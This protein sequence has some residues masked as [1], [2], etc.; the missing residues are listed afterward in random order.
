M[1]S[2]PIVIGALSVLFDIVV[3]GPFH[4]HFRQPGVLP[5]A[6]EALCLYGA[7]LLAWQRLPRFALGITIVVGWLY[8]RRHHVD[9][10]A[11]AGWIYLEGIVAFGALFLR[12][13]HDAGGRRF[14]PPGMSSMLVGVAIWLV[15]MIGVSALGMGRPGHLLAL[16]ALVLLPALALRWRET[17]ALQFGGALR[18]SSAGERAGLLALLVWMLVLLARTNGTEGYDS[19]WYPLRPDLVLVGANSFFDDLGL[20]HPVHYTLK[21]WELLIAPLAQGRDFSYMIAPTVFAMAG[22][23]WV[24]DVF[25]RD[26]FVAAPARVMALVLI[27]TVPAVANSALLAKA[28]VFAALLVVLA[29]VVSMRMAVLRTLAGWPWLL[30]ISM[31]AFGFKMNALPYLA[32]ILLVLVGWSV[33][34]WRERQRSAPVDPRASDRGDPMGWIAL[35]AT[36]LAVIGFM[37]RTWWLTGMPTVAPS[38]L[39]SLWQWLGF[40]LRPHIGG[41]EWAFPQRWGDV[42]RLIVDWLFRPSRMP[43]IVVTWTG[44]VWFVCSLMLLASFARRTTLPRTGIAAPAWPMLIVAITGLVLAVAIRYHSRGGDGNYF[45]PAVAAAIALS[46]PAL[47]SRFPH[48][49]HRIALA[50]ALV[51]MA[52]FQ[53][54]YAFVS[55]S[56]GEP[57]TRPFDLDFTRSVRDTPLRRQ[58]ALRADGLERIADYLSSRRDVRHGI[59]TVAGTPVYWLPARYESLQTFSFTRNE[60]VNDLA[61]LE[62]YVSRF[63]IDF[64]LVPKDAEGKPELTAYPVLPQL[65]ERIGPCAEI[66]DVKAVMYDLRRCRDAAADGR[67]IEAAPPVPTAG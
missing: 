50:S 21:G 39:V 57:G 14:M 37:L 9:A 25:L 1:I 52:L 38:I 16:A 20:V 65:L 61:A 28:D 54:S 58:D 3:T 8:L 23:L 35:V 43:H 34:F 29:A 51:V 19:L 42:P 33:W 44:N 6:I 18:E 46:V 36:S 7:L 66:D 60:L 48:S 62:V 45:I 31:L 56:W 26:R 15:S 49:V 27:A 17:L 30:A 40:E 64:V 55:A 32:V 59:G 5:G 63:G 41:L 67:R 4:W 12:H 53:A 24:V 2:A 13:R 11:L 10:P 22:L 47:W